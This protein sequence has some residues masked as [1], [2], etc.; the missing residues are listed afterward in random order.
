MG[1][2]EGIWNARVLQFIA[3][4][5]RLQNINAKEE[6]EDYAGTYRQKRRNKRTYIEKCHPWN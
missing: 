3:K 5:K 6:T 1:K 2:D 4:H